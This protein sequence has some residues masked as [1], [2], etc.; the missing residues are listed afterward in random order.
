MGAASAGCTRSVGRDAALRLVHANPK[1]LSTTPPPSSAA[2]SASRL[3]PRGGEGDVLTFL[4]LLGLD[5]DRNVGP[6][7]RYF[8]ALR[9]DG[10]GGGGV[11]GAFGYSLR[12]NRAARQVLRA[13]G[14]DAAVASSLL[15]PGHAA[16]VKRYAVGREWAL[17]VEGAPAAVAS[18]LEV[19]VG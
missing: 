7:L 1:V 6:K 16:F 4:P 15:A 9:A 14:V 13:R 3:E 10:G 18:F 5:V 8:S 17:A 11:A 19:Q 12:K 2:L